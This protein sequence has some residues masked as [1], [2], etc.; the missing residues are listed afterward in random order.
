MA[1]HCLWNEDKVT[2]T[3]KQQQ[4]KDMPLFAQSGNLTVFT[5]CLQYFSKNQHFFK[6]DEFK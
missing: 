5:L 2:N 4:Q 6:S 3:A 1:Q